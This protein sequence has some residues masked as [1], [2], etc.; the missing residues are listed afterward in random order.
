M[1]SVQWAFLLFEI[2]LVGAAFHF[3]RKTRHA[4]GIAVADMEAWRTEVELHLE[5]LIQELEIVLD[6]APAQARENGVARKAAARPDGLERL[7][8]SITDRVEVALPANGFTFPA[9][10]MPEDEPVV[11]EARYEEARRLHAQGL[12]ETTIARRTGLERE[13]VRLL[14]ALTPAPPEAPAVPNNGSGSA[15]GK[16]AE[17]PPANGSNGLAPYMS[18]LLD[19]LKESDRAL[20]AEE[21]RTILRNQRRRSAGETESEAP[22]ES[23]QTRRRRTAKAPASESDDGEAMPVFKATS[24]P[25]RRS[26]SRKGGAVKAQ[27]EG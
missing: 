21:G 26:R 12:D 10:E 4:M 7:A 23:T 27:E 14:F 13:E 2:A 15:P 20:T 11:V 3:Y 5:T 8:A 19:Y 24:T 18:T 22:I 1:T 17:A 25:Q 16:P 9:P 6:E